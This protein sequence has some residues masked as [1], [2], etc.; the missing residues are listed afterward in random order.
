MLPLQCGVN[1]AENIFVGSGFGFFSLGKGLSSLKV[2]CV[3]ALSFSLSTCL[4]T[5]GGQV[6]DGNR[7]TSFLGQLL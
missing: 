2:N 3:L 5:M 1:N 7:V 4:V 6:F